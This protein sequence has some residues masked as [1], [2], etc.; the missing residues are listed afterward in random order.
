MKRL[1]TI[2][3]MACFSALVSGQDLSGWLFSAQ[4]QL[5]SELDGRDFSNK[6]YPLTFT[7]LRSRLGVEKTFMDKV[8]IMIQAQDSRV[9][10]EEPSTVS[11][12]K[13]LDVHQAYFVL[14]DLFSLPFSLQ[15][16]RFEMKYGTERFIGAVGWNYIGRSFDGV[17]LSFSS[18]FKL[19]IF[20]N[21][22]TQSTGY[23]SAAVPANYPNPALPDASFSL[24]GFW[25]SFAPDKGSTLDF[26]GFYEADR[27][28]TPANASNLMR[29]TAGINYI[30]SFGQFS[31]ITEAAYQFGKQSDKTI[32]AYLL[33]IQGAYA[34]NP[35]KAG[36]GIDILSGQKSGSSKVTSF[37]VPYATNHKFY[38][39]MD[40][41]TNFPLHTLGLGLND[42]YLMFDF[43]PAGSLWSGSL[44][45]HHFTS[46][47]KSISGDRVF[48]QEADLTVRYQ[49]VK[50]TTL[51]WGGSIFLPGKLMK[52]NFGALTGNN[53]DTSFWSYLMATI[54]I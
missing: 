21:T 14:K 44:N 18:P 9:F 5:R 10:G 26:F 29:G 28:K 7:S 41:F 53:E 40:Y 4:L 30:A 51:T 48:G 37:S 35:F 16:G 32:G 50:G 24:Y 52:T 15:A 38:G 27:K 22:L 33:S 17:R 36:L 11:N 6:T 3:I 23:I 19:D 20:A 54:S 39:Y 46:N 31:A 13:N 1:I 45:V 25:S 47:L 12:T 43:N 34:F 8:T 2:V 49:F 42:F